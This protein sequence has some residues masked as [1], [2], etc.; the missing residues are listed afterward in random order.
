MIRTKAAMY[1][2][3][4]AGLLGNKPRTWANRDQLQAS[5]YRG[6][7]TIR[8]VASAGG[9]TR[10][11]VS[12]DEAIR[13]SFSWPCAH[14]F[15]ESMPDED[16]I[17]QGE[18]MRSET[19]WM[20]LSFDTVANRKFNEARAHFTTYYGLWSKLT[21]QRYLWPASYDDIVEMLDLY[22]GHVIEFSAYSKA[23]GD[24]THRNTVL[25]EIR[26]Y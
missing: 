14:N 4:R 2:L 23:V 26:S 17:L 3:W 12:Y 19:D 18:V 7:L 1:R 25:W 16:L 9:T 20:I 8:S 24:C 10:Y 5:G 6:E 13:L 21:L 15:N 22:P 11:R